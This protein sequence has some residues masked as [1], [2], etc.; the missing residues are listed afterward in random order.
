MSKK[1]KNLLLV[2][3]VLVLLF[4]RTYLANLNGGNDPADPGN[5]PGIEHD[6]DD[7]GKDPGTDDPSGG[8][9]DPSGEEKNPAVE[10]FEKEFGFSPDELKFRNNKLWSEHYD[11]HGKDMGFKNKEDYAAAAVEVVKNPESLHKTEKED[12]D[13]CF[14]VEDTNEF[15]VVSKDGYIRTYFL[16]DS[17][18]K[19]YN[20]Q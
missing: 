14:Y 17:G 6:I 3:L 16:P 10:W 7:P 1:S 2:V 15:V 11:K 13:Y 4:A 19:Y 18:I 9:E 5:D 20:K 8:N 12:G